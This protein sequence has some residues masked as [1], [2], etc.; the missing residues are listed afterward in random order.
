MS[1]LDRADADRVARRVRIIEGQHLLFSFLGLPVAGWAR[2]RWLS[3]FTGFAAGQS[4]H[5]DQAEPEV[6]DSGQQPVQ[7]GLIG[8]RPGDDRLRAIGLH[9]QA[10]EPGRPGWLKTPSTRIS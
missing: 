1:C 4:A 6:A 3:L 5:G 10:A 8:K 2:V 9:V 7:C